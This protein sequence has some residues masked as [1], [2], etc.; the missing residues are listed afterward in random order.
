MTKAA[1]N[2][3]CLQIH[4]GEPSL[5]NGLQEQL[6]ALDFAAFARF[7][8]L[9]LERL[10]YD[11]VQPAGRAEPQGKAKQPREGIGWDLEA[12]V[13]VGPHRRRVIVALK[14]Y[15]PHKK[16]RR[17]MA[18][19]MRGVCLRAGAS[20]ALLITTSDLPPGMDEES[21][22]GPVAPVRVIGGEELLDLCIVHRVGVWEEV[23]TTP[24]ET[25][26]YGIDK[27]YFALLTRNH[28]SSVI[29]QPAKNDTAILRSGVL[30]RFVLTLNFEP[31][32]APSVVLSAL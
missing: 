30:G 6:L 7:V 11:D 17:R 32:K 28:Q 8:S 21:R 14:H 25:S 16:V 20:E 22:G 31:D 26:R 9:L 12:T 27:N 23:G 5:R 10:G 13:A 2:K 19:E 24:K 3:P 4:L 29:M 18:D 15:Q 1:P